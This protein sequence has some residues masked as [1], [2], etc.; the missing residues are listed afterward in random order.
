MKND[1]AREVGGVAHVISPYENDYR[2][3]KRLSSVFHFLALMLRSV[4]KPDS[5]RILH[6][7][8]PYASTIQPV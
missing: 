5:N 8:S 7:M 3:Q 1:A 6:S 4:I 2:G